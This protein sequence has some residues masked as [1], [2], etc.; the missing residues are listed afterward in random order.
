M[1][2]QHMLW[3]LQDVCRMGISRTACLLPFEDGYAVLLGLRILGMETF[4]LMRAR[5]M[6]VYCTLRRMATKL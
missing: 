3:Q 6:L 2:W 1:L 5:Y 4:G